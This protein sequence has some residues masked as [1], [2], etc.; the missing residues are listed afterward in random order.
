[1][2]RLFV[3]LSLPEQITARIAPMMTGLPGARWLPPESLHVT[4]R[5]I[6]DVDERD[7]AILDQSLTAIRRPSFDLTIT[8]CGIFAQKR[9]PEAVWLGVHSSQPLLDLQGAVERAAVRAGN[10]PEEHRYRPHVTLAR[11]RDTPQQRLQSFV[12]GHNLFKE[13]VGIDH[14]ALFSSILGKE[15]AK[16]TIEATYPLDVMEQE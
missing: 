16:Y 6:G 1:M 11:L 2:M 3:G 13:Q 12:A 14:F 9:G 15:Q 4:L 10:A 8:G 5:F 7:A